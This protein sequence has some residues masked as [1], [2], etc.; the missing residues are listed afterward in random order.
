M[1]LQ[2]TSPPTSPLHRPPAMLKR[3]HDLVEDE[4]DSV[5]MAMTTGSG[6]KKICVEVVCADRTT[7][8]LRSTSD[9]DEPE[10]YR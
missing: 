7:S 8:R 1:G 2:A 10:D 4:E 5:L 6:V 3:K 9:D